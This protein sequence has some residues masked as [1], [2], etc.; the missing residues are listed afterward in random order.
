M[1]EI[2]FHQDLY[3]GSAVDEALQVFRKFAAFDRAE[4]PPYWVVRVSGPSDRRERLVARE[5]ANYALGLTVHRR[6]GR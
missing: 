2:R 1:T 3:V 5:L 6:G 4:E